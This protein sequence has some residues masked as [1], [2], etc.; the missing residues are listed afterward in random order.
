MKYCKKC[1]HA[2][3]DDAM[4]CAKCGNAL[5]KGSKSKNK[6]TGVPSFI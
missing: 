3:A 5:G 6:K 4:F 2:N 1:G